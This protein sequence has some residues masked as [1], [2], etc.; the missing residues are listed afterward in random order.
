MILKVNNCTFLD[1]FAYYKGGG[2]YLNSVLE[3]GI[4]NSNFENN[5]VFLDKM[6]ENYQK[7]SNYSLS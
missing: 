4:Y 5:K 2:L 1:S 6:I 7:L 3:V